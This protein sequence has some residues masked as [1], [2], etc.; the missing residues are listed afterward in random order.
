MNKERLRTLSYLSVIFFAALGVLYIG[1]R[2][3]LPVALPFLLSC[4]IAIMVKRPADAL[5]GRMHLPKRL[6]RGALALILILALL[7]AVIFGIVRLSTEAVGLFSSLSENGSLSDIIGIL[8]DPF[9]AFVGNVDFAP[10]LADKLS[11]AA[12]GII[13]EVLTR[14]ASVLTA[15]VSSIP[16]IALFIIVTS[17]ST[18]YFAVDLEAIGAAILAVL[19]DKTEEKLSQWRKNLFGVVIKYARSYLLLMLLTFSI[20]IFGLSLMHVRYALLLAALISLLD[21]LP[22]IGVGTVLVPWSVWSFVTG[23]VKFAICLI[24]LFG[25]NEVVRQIAEPKIFGMN[26]GLHPLLTLILLY[27]GYSLLGLAGLLL[28]PVVSVL[29]SAVVN[30]SKT[31]NVEQKVERRSE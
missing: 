7:G 1:V 26:L 6:M 13:S 4:L 24:V 10:E 2:Y 18:V 5:A 30:K 12:S 21:L 11:G 25:V 31:A 16:K 14:L 23:D 29:V 27:A 17:V 22:I 28:L 9:D 20:M 8:L 3:A 19:P 15:T